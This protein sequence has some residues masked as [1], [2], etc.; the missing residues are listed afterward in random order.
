M[1]DKSRCDRRLMAGCLCLRICLRLLARV[2]P[3]PLNLEWSTW[4]DCCCE[5]GESN[6]VEFRYRSETWNTA[7][8]SETIG[9]VFD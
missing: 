5:G 7:V 6:A 4:L 9:E 2:S 3:E 8:F 1:E